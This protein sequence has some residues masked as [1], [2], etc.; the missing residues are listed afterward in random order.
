MDI[1]QIIVASHVVATILGTGGATIAE[2]QITRALKD[3]KVSD[4]E[5]ALMHVN[6]TMIRVGMAIMLVSVIA[7][8]WYHLSQGNDFIIFSEKLWIKDLMFIVIIIN[9]VVLTK[10]WIPLWLGASVSFTSWWGATLLGLTG[11]L[12]YDFTTYLIGYIFAIFIVAYL[13]R[14]THRLLAK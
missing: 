2:F 14:V 7:M 1:Y 8:F 13:L 10:R 4:E 3:K 9:A 6:Y 11:R 12:P 5:R